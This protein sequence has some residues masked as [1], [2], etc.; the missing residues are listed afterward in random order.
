MAQNVSPDTRRGKRRAARQRKRAR[1]RERAQQSQTLQQE[2]GKLSGET[3]VKVEEPEQEQDTAQVQRPKPKKVGHGQTPKIKQEPQSQ[4]PDAAR[5]VPLSADDW[6]PSKL[7]SDLRH[8]HFAS[9][10]SVSKP[11]GV[12]DHHLDLVVAAGNDFCHK[13]ETFSCHKHAQGHDVS[14]AAITRLAMACPNL[15]TVNLMSTTRLTDESVLAFLKHCP[16]LRT[17]TIVGNHPTKGNVTGKLAFAELTRNKN[18]GKNLQTL[19]LVD[20]RVG[21]DDMTRLSRAR[22]D[23]V[24]WGT[25]VIWHG[26]K[27]ALDENE[28]FESEPEHEYQGEYEYGD[29]LT[30]VDIQDSLPIWERDYHW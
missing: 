6:H 27:V 16:G 25:Y 22:K 11:F 23:L 8:L 2:A 20:Q 4:P 12:K 14:D 1:R 3:K 19:K 26:G 29:G 7:P 21:R 28:W 13:L 9:T 30:W 15:Q 5:A 17:L 24:V 10:T 18:L